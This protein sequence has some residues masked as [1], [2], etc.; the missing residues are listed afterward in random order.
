[1]DWKAEVPITLTLRFNPNA[2]DGKK[3]VRLDERVK[4]LSSFA[5]PSSGPG[6]DATRT[7]RSSRTSSASSTTRSREGSTSPPYR[8]RTKKR[9]YSFT[10]T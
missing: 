9:S 7:T 8:G 5:P 1:M 6:P 2:F 4:A 3:V 10:G